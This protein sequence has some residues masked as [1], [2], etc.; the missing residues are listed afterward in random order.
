MWEDGF[1]QSYGKLPLRSG[2]AAEGLSHS[3]IDMAI[4]QQLL[5]VG[6]HFRLQAHGDRFTVATRRFRNFAPFIRQEPSQ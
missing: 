4:F 2:T 1:L 6:A 5:F 3:M